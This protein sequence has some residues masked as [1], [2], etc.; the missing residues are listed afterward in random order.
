MTNWYLA[1]TVPTGDQPY[2]LR[3]HKWTPYIEDVDDRVKAG[4]VVLI[5]NQ[6]NGIF[7]WGTVRFRGEQTQNRKSL[8]EI[9]RGDLRYSLIPAEVIAEIQELSPIINSPKRPFTFLTKQQ[10]RAAT[11]LLTDPKPPEPIG[12]HFTLGS[13]VQTDEDLGI[14]YKDV[15]A[16]QVA[17]VA[18]EYAVAYARGN[19]GHVYFGIDDNGEVVGLPLDF[20]QRRDLRQ[21]IEEKLF[22]IDPPLLANDDYTISFEKVIDA[23]G[24]P[25]LHTFVIDVEIK[26]TG[27]DHRTAGGKSFHKG[28]SGRRKL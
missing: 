7:A 9:D 12:N 24:E 18:Y 21:R 17:K 3:S 11:S 26:P 1:F 2:W 25:I 10:M 28:F 5:G 27:N 22:T 15:A 23:D 16:S 8:V 4:D 19:G 20:S 14:E 13:R 6:G